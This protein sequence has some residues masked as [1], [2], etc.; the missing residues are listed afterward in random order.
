MM[1]KENFLLAFVAGHRQWH[2]D[3][4]V[5]CRFACNRI[6]ALP[7]CDCGKICQCA[8]VDACKGTRTEFLVLKNNQIVGCDLPSVEVVS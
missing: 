3:C 2:L 4:N 5:I 1:I 7:T 6:F 8:L